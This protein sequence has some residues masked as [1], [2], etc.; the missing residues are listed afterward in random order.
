MPGVGTDWA[1]LFLGTVRWIEYQK[2]DTEVIIERLHF[3]YNE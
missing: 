2:Y 3:V 1:N